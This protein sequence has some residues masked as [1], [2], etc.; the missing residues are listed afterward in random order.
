M[1]ESEDG[2]DDQDDVVHVVSLEDPVPDKSDAVGERADTLEE[3]EPCLTQDEFDEVSFLEQAQSFC[4]GEPLISRLVVSFELR[5]ELLGLLGFLD[6]SLRVHGSL[7]SLVSYIPFIRGGL[8]NVK[9]ESE[10]S[11][12]RFRGCVVR[13]EL[14]PGDGRTRRVWRGDVSRGC[15]RG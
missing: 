7:S 8:E 11:L 5:V 14:G 9:K 6:S 13:R 3:L 2:D 12:G 10:E 4:S 1:Y 15:T